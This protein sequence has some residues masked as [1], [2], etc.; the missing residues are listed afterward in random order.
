MELLY[1]LPHRFVWLSMLVLLVAV[2]LK[3]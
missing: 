1:L 2:N 3:L